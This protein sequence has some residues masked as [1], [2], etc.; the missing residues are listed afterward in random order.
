MS[1]GGAL[2]ICAVFGFAEKYFRSVMPNLFGITLAYTYL[3]IGF[4]KL[5]KQ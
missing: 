1:D 2:E 3:C 4:E 5:L